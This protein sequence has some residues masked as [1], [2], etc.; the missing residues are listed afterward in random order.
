[1][2]SANKSALSAAWYNALTVIRSAKAVAQGNSD[3]WLAKNAYAFNPLAT[4][5]L[6]SKPNRNPCGRYF[7]TMRILA[8]PLFP[9]ITWQ[10]PPIPRL[11]V[12]IRSVA[13]SKSRRVQMIAH[14][15][16]ASA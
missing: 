7:A 15:K 10:N 6:V 2:P 5:D 1:M 9:H 11:C 8:Q 12:S 3:V 16:R 4:T 13:V 14:Y